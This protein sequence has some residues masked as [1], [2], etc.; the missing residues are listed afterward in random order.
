[1]KRKILLIEP[2]YKNKYPPIGLMKISSYHKSL[3]DEVTF[4]KGNLKDL[5]LDQIVTDCLKSLNDNNQQVKWDLNYFYIKNYIKTGMKKYLSL[6]FPEGDAPIKSI[7]I[8]RLYKDYYRKKEYVNNPI[9]DRIYITTLFTF[10]W[11]KT[12]DCINFSK[13]LVKDIN[14][15][16]VGGV[17]ASI[18]PDEIYNETGVKPY[19]G[20]LNKPFIIDKDNSLIIDEMPLDYSI[21]HEIDYRYP[22]ND[23]FY[24]YFTR[25]C[26]RNCS[27]CAVPTI[28][29]LYDSFIS[30]SKSIIKT[31][32]EFG[33]K[34]NLLLLDN[35]VLASKNFEDIINEIIK[36]GFYK[37]SKFRNPNLLEVYINNLNNNINDK[38][39][40]DLLYN[41]Y[42]SLLKKAKKSDKEYILNILETKNI[43]D[44]LNV[45]K[46]KLKSIYPELNNIYLKYLS[47]IPKKRRV[48]FNQGLDARLLTEKKIKLLSKIAINPM[49]IAFDDVKDEEVYIKAIKLSAS[50]DVKS[51]SNYLLYNEKDHPNDLYKRLKINIDLCEELNISIY[52]FPMKFHPIFGD[53]NKDRNFLGQQWNRKF[54]RSI[55]IILNATKGKVG[56]SK[57]FFEKAFGKDLN[58]YIELLYMPEVYIL[59]RYFFENIGYT[60]K[61]KEQFNSLTCNERDELK[62]I[63]K[64]ND[65]T[66]KK[67]NINNDRIRLILKHYLIK[68]KDVEDSSTLIGKMKIEYDCKKLNE[69]R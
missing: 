48:D 33:D 23:A 39:Y 30:F 3:G 27:F 46:E 26:I 64:D 69:I 43:I 50:Y 54:I 63:I 25:G 22:E 65:I 12:I 6:M 5:V 42:L 44:P 31:R 1:M 14:N 55:Q 40:T 38:V 34:R 47:K 32:G 41:E 11:K 61:W 56:R 20:L 9:W 18:L 16:M 2:N 28:E 13:M 4:F 53:H 51:F 49:R 52:S 45:T 24:G 57:S 59:Y 15:L 67:I 66:Q 60:N 21:L 29:P 36:C 19:V 8:L 10:Y 58:E 62:Q 17:M 37:D 7:Q 35:N 68:S